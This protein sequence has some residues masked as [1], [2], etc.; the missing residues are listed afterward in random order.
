VA[1]LN[2]VGVQCGGPTTA[3]NDGGAGTDGGSDTSAADAVP[4][5]IDDFPVANLVAFPGPDT[6]GHDATE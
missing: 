2:Y 1:T 3:S 4:E 5:V 6:G